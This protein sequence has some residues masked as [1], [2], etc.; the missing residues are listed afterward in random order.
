M[1]RQLGPATFA[2]LSRRFQLQEAGEPAFRRQRDWKSV[3]RLGLANILDWKQPPERIGLAFGGGSSEGL[4]HGTFAGEEDERT[5]ALGDIA[6]ESNSIGHRQLF[7][8]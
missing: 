8:A 6:L 2:F 5:A 4:R 1:A 7:G 3:N